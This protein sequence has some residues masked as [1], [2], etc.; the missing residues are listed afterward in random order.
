[1]RFIE[2]SVSKKSLST[3]GP[4]MVSSLGTSHWF[5]VLSSQLPSFASESSDPGL[6]SSA[7][8]KGHK[9]ME[10]THPNTDMKNSNV[11]QGTG[12][13][14]LGSTQ[15][16]TPV[17]PSCLVMTKLRMNTS[18]RQMSGH[19]TNLFHFFTE[20]LQARNRAGRAPCQPQRP[21]R[22]DRLLV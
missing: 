16:K 9:F 18:K 20:C 8:I 13:I 12:Y 10:L 22:L 7:L 2:F 5:W 3:R 6:H 14:N 21:Q 15:C 19:R 17:C 1:M 4:A 11:Q